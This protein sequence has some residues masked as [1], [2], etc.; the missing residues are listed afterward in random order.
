MIRQMKISNFKSINNQEIELKPL[1]IFTGTNSS[2]KTTLMQSILLLSYYSN[3]NSEL[4][5]ALIKVKKF[6]EVRNFNN[7]SNEVTLQ[8]KIDNKEYILKCDINSN[9]II[10]YIKKNKIKL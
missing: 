3:Q 5:K 10:N 8:I 7:N 2:G 4:E 1:T 6:Q 9:W